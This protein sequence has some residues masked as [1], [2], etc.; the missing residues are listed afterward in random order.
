MLSVSVA[1]R[2]SSKPVHSLSVPSGRVMPSKNFAV[3][4]HSPGCITI[5]PGKPSNM[6]K[7]SFPTS[8][9]QVAA[10]GTAAGSVGEVLPATERSSPLTNEE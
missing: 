1:L 3:T 10:A 5:S 7:K 4:S 2:R 6:S 9:V 8:E